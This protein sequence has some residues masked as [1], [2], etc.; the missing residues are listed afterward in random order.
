MHSSWSKEHL[1]NG[2][3]KPTVVLVARHKLAFAI[4]VLLYAHHRRLLVDQLGRR[5]LQGGFTYA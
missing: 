3:C 5:S 1:E 4:P 2:L